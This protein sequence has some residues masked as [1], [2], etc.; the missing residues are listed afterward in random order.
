MKQKFIQPKGREKIYKIDTLK[1]NKKSRWTESLGRYHKS[2][3]ITHCQN[4]KQ[5]KI[6]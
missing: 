4:Q 3:D 5:L 2:P 1:T 6:E